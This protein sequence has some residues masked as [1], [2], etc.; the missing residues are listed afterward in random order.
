LPQKNVRDLVYALAEPVIVENGIE[1]VDVEF[2]K[3]GGNWYLRL[4]IDKEK[5][6]DLDDCEKISHLISDLLDKEDPI[7]Q[8]YF[9]E[10]SSPGLDRPLKREKDF[11]KYEGHAVNVRTYSPVEGKKKI[12]GKL[13]AYHQDYLKLLL[14]SDQ[15]I[16]IPWDL[17]AQ[18]RLNWEEEERRKEK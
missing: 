18:V 3:E 9:L 13:G 16:Q 10:V 6:I 7:E 5:G 11:R 15:E 2:V 12:Q 1:L 8:A 17:V 14:K 4:Y